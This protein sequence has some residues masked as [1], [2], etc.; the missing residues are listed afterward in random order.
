M[1][2]HDFD[3]LRRQADRI[4]AEAGQFA[5]QPV[6]QRAPE[7]PVARVHHRHA[8]LRQ[9]PNLFTLIKLPIAAHGRAVIQP[10]ADRDQAVGDGLTQVAD[11]IG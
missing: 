11:Q 5:P 10:H 4:R 2:A 8:H 7:L 1:R 9:T 6:E 3:R